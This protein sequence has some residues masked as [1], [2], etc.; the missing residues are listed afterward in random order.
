[1][2]F[3]ESRYNFS[4]LIF[5]K[6]KQPKFFI[7]ENA[8]GFMTLKKD[9]IFNRVCEEYNKCGYNLSAKLLNSAD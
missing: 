1:M 4:G 8:K 3:R 6:N 5:V 9:A 7:A 2:D